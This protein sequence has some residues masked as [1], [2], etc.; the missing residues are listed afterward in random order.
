ML[1]RIPTG[2]RG[3]SQKRSYMVDIYNRQ[4]MYL[5]YLLT[6]FDK[7][8]VQYEVFMDSEKI[9]WVSKSFKAFI[10]YVKTHAQIFWAPGQVCRALC[11][12]LVVDEI[13]IIV[14]ST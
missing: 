3:L 8:G 6:D 4:L 9:C 10:P 2:G 14:V 12:L 11:P 5:C 7:L 1:S 13:L